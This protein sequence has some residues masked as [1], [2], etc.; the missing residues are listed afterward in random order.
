LKT[1]ILVIQTPHYD[2]CSASLIQGLIELKRLGEDIEIKCVETSNYAEVKD[3]Y[4]YADFDDKFLKK[5]AKTDHFLCILTSNNNVQE[6][7]AEQIN[8]PENTIYIDGED[9]SPYKKKPE[10]FPLY[11]KREM[12][13]DIEHPHNV[14]PFPFAAENR[15]FNLQRFGIRSWKDK[16]FNV[17]CMFG[18]HDDT[19][20]WRRVI[21][22]KLK[23]ME[24][25]NSSI[26]PLYGGSPKAIIDTGNRDHSDYFHVL[27]L[28][29]ISV[30][31][32]GA[33]G[34]NAARFWESL[35]NQCCLI[36]QP[37][38]IHMHKPFLLDEHLLEFKNT[39]NLEDYIKYS[40]PEAIEKIAKNGF[41]HLRKYHT[42]E[43][44]AKYLIDQC[45]NE[46]IIV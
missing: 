31:G 44:R 25:E 5:C 34:C 16:T 40:D 41:N 38:K 8:R 43:Y 39:E 4:T 36:T 46:G 6:H 21:E 28:S 17:S 37:I 14:R 22:A 32:Y 42:T 1:T 45:R 23:T 12:M 15:Y 9:T 3:K 24:L 30:D 18:P 10:D 26:G 27:A 13:L 2:F 7:I 11:F 35:A 20:P 19:K 29:K 33:F